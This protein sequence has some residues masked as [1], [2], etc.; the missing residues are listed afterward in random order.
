M[1]L[2]PETGFRESYRIDGETLITVNDYR[3]GKNSTMRSATRFILS[4][5]TPKT[6]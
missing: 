2:Q 1:H 6:A 4:I 3:S 5:S